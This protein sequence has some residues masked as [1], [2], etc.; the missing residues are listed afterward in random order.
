MAFLLNQSKS[1]KNPSIQSQCL[2]TVQH[3]AVSFSLIRNLPLYIVVVIDYA[4]T[5]RLQLKTNLSDCDSDMV[6]CFY[7]K[8][9]LFMIIINL[10]E[11]MEESQTTWEK[12]TPEVISVENQ[13]LNWCTHDSVLEREETP[14]TMWDVPCSR[15]VYPRSNGENQQLNWCTHDSVLAREKHR[16]QCETCLVYRLAI[17]LTAQIGRILTRHD[18]KHKSCQI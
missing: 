6:Q 7:W 9:V 14:A 11:A 15:L 18:M 2:N 8:K 1:T 13:Q 3:G 10:N 5:K 4:T 17:P 16:Q 12:L